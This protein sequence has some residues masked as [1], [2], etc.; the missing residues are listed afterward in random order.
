MIDASAMEDVPTEF[1]RDELG[2]EKQAGPVLGQILCKALTY[3]EPPSNSAGE[4]AAKAGK[5]MDKATCTLQKTE[6]H[7]FVESNA[8]I[9]MYGPGQIPR[10]LLW[11]VKRLPMLIIDNFNSTTGRNKKFRGESYSRRL[12]S[13]K[14]S[15]L[16]S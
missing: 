10:A 3:V 6:T 16:L 1:S 4:F 8:T 11:I 7:P 9:Y 14:F 2:V 13:S 15:S 12:L 5:A